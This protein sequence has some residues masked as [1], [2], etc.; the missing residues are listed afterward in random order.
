M[1]HSAPFLVLGGI[2]LAACADPGSTSTSSSAG[3]AD[4]SRAGYDQAGAHRQYGVPVSV[5]QG[6]AR[7]YVVLDEKN[8]GTPLEIGVALDERALDGLPAGMAGAAPDEFGMPMSMGNEYILPLP[9]HNPTPYQLVVLNWNP[10]GHAP[11]QLYGKPHFDFHFYTIDNATRLSIV[12]SDPD[13][14]AKAANFPGAKMPPGYFPPPAPPALAAVPMMGLHWSDP[15]SPEF[16]PAG[17]SRTFIYGSWDG[18]VTF[19]EPMIT[20]AYLLTHPDVLLDLPIPTEFA[21]S[22]YFPAAYRVVFDAQAGEYRVALAKLTW[23]E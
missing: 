18:E 8:G 22:G 7:T 12:P 2:L 14:A 17:F 5:G 4:Y 13:Y 3:A 23:R 16:S 15:T 11:P 19:A 10:N 21:T 1:R 9:T 6:R 20:R